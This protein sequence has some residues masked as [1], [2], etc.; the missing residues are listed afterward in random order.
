M[1]L[2]LRGTA[3]AN[4]PTVHPPDDTRM[5]MKQRWNDT[6]NAKLKDS[7]RN[8]TSASSSTTNTRTALS[9]KPGLRGEKPATN[10]LSYSTTQLLF[11][12]LVAHINL[13]TVDLTPVPW[14][15]PNS[16]QFHWAVNGN[17][18]SYSRRIYRQHRSPPTPVTANTGHRQH[19]SPPT[20]VTSRSICI[21][22]VE[23]STHF[24][25][26]FSM[27]NLNDFPVI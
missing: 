19:R 7:Q 18:S 25:L 15:K 3:A 21:S 17:Y 22:Q 14:N 9:A 26:E 27:M 12:T 4:G 6:D 1:R 8:L 16:A 2:R 24:S 23:N 13:I 20:P 5:N 11:T 10:R